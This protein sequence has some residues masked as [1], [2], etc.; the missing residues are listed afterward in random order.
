MQILR[1]KKSNVDLTSHL[2]SKSNTNLSSLMFEGNILNKIP[3]LHLL[4]LQLSAGSGIIL[5]PRDD[6]AH[7]EIYFGISR[8]FQIKNQI[9]KLNTFAVTSANTLVGA[10]YQ[11]KFGISMYD[12]F[13]KK[14]DY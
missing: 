2:V 13:N 5:V 1:T 11:F 3:F 4:K 6:L 7:A 10:N 14:W 8:R 12:P 9:F